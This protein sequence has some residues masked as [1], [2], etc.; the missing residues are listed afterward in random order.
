MY[1]LFSFIHLSVA[2]D[3]AVI[4]RQ[5]FDAI[6]DLFLNFYSSTSSLP[7]VH[8]FHGNRRVESKTR[9]SFWA[10]FCIFFV[11]STCWTSILDSLSKFR[12]V[13]KFMHNFSPCAENMGFFDDWVGYTVQG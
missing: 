3:K 1:I 5:L 8:S 11:R 10:V 4:A 12:C 6:L 2:I 7:R 9:P 13:S